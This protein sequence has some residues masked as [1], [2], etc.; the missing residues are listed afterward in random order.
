MRKIEDAK[1]FASMKE[2]GVELDHK[3]EKIKGKLIAAP[4]LALGQDRA[5]DKGR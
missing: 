5:V 1:D 4:K 2:I 3:M